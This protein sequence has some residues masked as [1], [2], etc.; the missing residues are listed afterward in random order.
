VRNVNDL[1]EYI[2]LLGVLLDW[3]G[4]S[5][6]PCN[7]LSVQ[8]QF[9]ARGFSNIR[10]HQGFVCGR[11]ATVAAAPT[12]SMVGITLASCISVYSASVCRARM[13]DTQFASLRADAE[14]AAGR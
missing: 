5:L 10:S 11:V 6:E 7:K 1:E 8:G 13:I 12:I 4:E 14:V 9:S 2:R 3:R